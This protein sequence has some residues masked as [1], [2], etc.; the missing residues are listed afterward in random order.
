MSPARS[1]TAASNPSVMATDAVR[2]IGAALMST[3]ATTTPTHSIAV[4]TPTI[5]RAHHRVRCDLVSA[6]A[7]LSQS[8]R[9]RGATDA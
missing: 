6:I 5:V 4:T 2:L 7:P 3:K 9:R 8:R 1:R